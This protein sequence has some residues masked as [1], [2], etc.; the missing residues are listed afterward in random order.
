M[1]EELAIAQ[2]G[3]ATRVKRSWKL[4]WWSWRCRSGAGGSERA[5][6]HAGN[7]TGVSRIRADWQGRRVTL[8]RQ[9]TLL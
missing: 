3:E 5:S 6:V 9:K 4:G 7:T 1:H 8:T 2:W